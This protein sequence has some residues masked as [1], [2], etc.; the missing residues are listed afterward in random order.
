MEIP[1]PGRPVYIL[2]YGTARIFCDLPWYKTTDV[3]HVQWH[4]I[5]GKS[6]VIQEIIFT[7]RRTITLYGIMYGAI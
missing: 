6:V 1:M 5:D 2:R 4:H 3:D 7:V